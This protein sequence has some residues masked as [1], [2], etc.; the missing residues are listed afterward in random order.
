MSVRP[1]HGRLAH[2][3]A[4]RDAW[5]LAVVLALAL[6]VSWVIFERVIRVGDLPGWDEACHCLW[7]LL[8]ADDL[9]H[10][11]FVGILVDTSRQVYW[12]PLHS[13]YLALAFIVFG[14]STVLARSSSL[15]A[16]V[17]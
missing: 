17:A 11:R 4:A 10:A 6:A 12:P 5:G 13:W 2:A 9:V 16:F 15:L 14:P 1:T 8:I 3:G 7:G